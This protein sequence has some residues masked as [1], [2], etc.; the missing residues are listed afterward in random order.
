MKK[1]EILSP[2]SRTSLFNPP[3][4]VAAIVRH[5]TFSPEDTALIRQRRAATRG[6]EIVA[7]GEGH[8]RAH[9][10]SMRIDF[11]ITPHTSKPDASL[12]SMFSN[13]GFSACS[14]VRAPFL[15]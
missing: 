8:R 1:H 11:A 4:D 3:T 15:R 7:I 14:Q 12:I 13:A 6:V 5:D 9:D 10:H 2:Q